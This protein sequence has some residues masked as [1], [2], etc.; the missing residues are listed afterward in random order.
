MTKKRGKIDREKLSQ[1]VIEKRKRGRGSRNELER[2][3]L[4]LSWLSKHLLSYILDHIIILLHVWVVM[5][6]GLSCYQFN[7]LPKLRDS[8]VK[9]GRKRGKKREK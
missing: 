9:R 1:N 2:C 8:G 6:P 3:Q 4:G 5:S 7:Q